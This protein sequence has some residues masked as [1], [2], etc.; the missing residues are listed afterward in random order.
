MA[1]SAASC[2]LSTGSSVYDTSEEKTNGLRLVRLL[3]DGGTA[4]LRNFL[5][6]VYPPEN[7][8]VVLK[9]NEAKLQRLKSKGVIFAT[10]WEMLFPPSGDP[11]NA[12][13]FD[14]TLLYLLLRNVCYLTVPSTGWHEI[15]PHD[16]D[17]P[18]ANIVRIKCYRN[19]LSHRASTE[20][21]N[22]EFEDI[23]TKISLAIVA[24]E[25]SVLRKKI[26]AL[27][28]DPIDRKTQQHL[29]ENVKRWRKLEEQGSS[30]A[31]SDIHSCL[32]DKLPDKLLF[33]RSRETQQ[34]IDIIEE[35][36]IPVA[37][38]TGGPGFGK[39]TV[40]ISVAH[41]LA[42]TE[43]NRAVLF[44]SLS[45]RASLNEVATEMIHSCGEIQTKLPE[46]PEQW[47]KNWSKQ[48][49]T[50][51]TFV[52]DHA[53]DILD[54]NCREQFL[55]LLRTVRMLS[56]QRVTYVITTRKTF[57][58]SEMHFDEIRL[59]PL[60]P[61]EAKNI[62][63][64]RVYDKEV[65]KKLS[66]TEEIVELCGFVPLALC[67][68]GSLLLD[69]PEERLIKNL[70]EKPLEVLKDDQISVKKAIKTSFDLL[71][72][73]EQDALVLMSVFP[74]SFD[75][76]AAEAI[77]EACANSR[78]LPIS[79]LRSLKNRSLVEQP[80]SQRYQLHSL[81]KAFAK[82][83]CTSAPLL[84]VGE[85]VACAHYMCRL[86][87]NVNLF[88][89]KDTCK[90]SFDAFDEDRQ[91][92]EH[93]L[94]AYT[95]GRENGDIAVMDSCEEFLTSLPQ[96]LMYLE[97]CV[98]PRFYT[99]FLTKLNGTIHPNT[100]PEHKVELYCLL[101]HEIRKEGK[102][103]EYEVC[104]EEA[105]KLYLENKTKFDENPLSEVIYLNSH[106]RLISKE[107][108]PDKPKEVYERALKICE[109]K[110]SNHPERA[111]T[112]L[113]AGR[114]SKRRNEY[115]RAEE[116]LNQALDLSKKCLGEHI[117]TAQCFKDIADFLFFAK[118]K[119]PKGE[120]G[121]DA[122]LSYYEK[123]LEMLEHLGRDGHKE[124]I[125]T[126]KNCGICHSSNGNYEEA[127]K[128]LEKAERVAERELENDHK[129]KVMVKTEQALVFYK[130]NKEE[131]M[132]E[133]MQN[134]L[135]MCYRLGM[136]V[137]DL[138]NRHQIREVLDRHPE[139][140]PKDKYP[141]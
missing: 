30:D 108:I 96:K 119:L 66:K 7:L 103:E 72:K 107:R 55:S 5:Y 22:G 18:E 60:L 10:Q 80:S 100:H 92:F 95:Q 53:D 129:W 114:N 15:P 4:I 13:V 79:I 56:E 132:I 14:I 133:A 57:Q 17:S 11:P 128:F 69:F 99:E 125:L 46:N 123:S 59:N 101:G 85:K 65:R 83:V 34:V 89:G 118:R 6:S 84:A 54:S 127:R 9:N 23:W 43:N 86:A 73:P 49:H 1:A 112:F 58:D 61:E 29:E 48:I 104:M 52:L 47:L 37:L 71:E 137:K 97:K 94:L 28:T 33:G 51:V 16:D 26:E 113:F 138:G 42:R 115:K 122:V 76:D 64:S 111:A 126:L 88:W 131:E 130:E 44:C 41:E 74:G 124:T 63:V 93:F 82:N 102:K 81:I 50:R 77:V 117:M 136:T 2:D 19:D 25:G 24:L 120:R 35:G 8:Q 70:K 121:F 135:E 3:I 134:G 31:K 75:S 91:N 141:R 78:T 90:Q 106:A 38:I 139:K 20:I 32:P 140:F 36:T 40:A 109:Q 45:S 12:E 27:K 62:L 110:L 39:T 98:L 21:S 67:V 105:E 87:K 68:V 116:Q